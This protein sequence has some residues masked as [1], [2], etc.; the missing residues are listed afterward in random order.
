MKASSAR[1][2][3]ADAATKAIIAGFDLDSKGYT[4]MVPRDEAFSSGGNSSTQPADILDAFNVTV[5]SLT[6]ADA[7]AVCSALLSLIWLLRAAFSFFF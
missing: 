7:T 1:V 5:A 6:T 4:L 2:Q 3:K